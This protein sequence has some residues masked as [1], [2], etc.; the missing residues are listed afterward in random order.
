M[1]A[2]LINLKPWADLTLD[3]KQQRIIEDRDCAVYELRLKIEGIE[4]EIED[5][6]DTMALRLA[7][8]ERG[9]SGL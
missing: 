6:H 4:D 8:L 9:G 5:E 7:D 1:G 3:E 2:K